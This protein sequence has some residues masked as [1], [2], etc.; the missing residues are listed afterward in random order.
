M[1]LLLLSL[2]NVLKDHLKTMTHFSKQESL[3]PFWLFPCQIDTLYEL[4]SKIVE[5]VEVELF[6]EQQTPFV[7]LPN[8]RTEGKSMA[9]L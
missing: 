7:C 1:N 5:N 3:Y 2:R 6:L 8:P 4:S 9:K